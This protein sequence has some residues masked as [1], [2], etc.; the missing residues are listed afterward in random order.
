MSSFIRTL[1]QWN[2]QEIQN[3]FDNAST[4][5]KSKELTILVAPSLLPHGRILIITPKKIGGAPVRNKLRR[6]VKS[7]F[8]EHKLYAFSKDLAFIPK[9][10][11]DI[12]SF[13]KLETILIKALKETHAAPKKN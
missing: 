6:R 2:Q 5:Y 10:G 8:Y 12:Y 3:L 13:E 1:S 9:P 11:I 7:I 4:A